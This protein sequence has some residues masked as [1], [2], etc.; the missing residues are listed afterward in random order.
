MQ[1]K[2]RKGKSHV[3]WRPGTSFQG[4]YSCGVTQ[5]ALSSSSIKSWQPVSS[6]VSQGSLL[7]TGF[8]RF[9][10]GADHKGTLCPAPMAFQTPR[11]NA[12]VQH[13]PQCLNKQ[14]R[15]HEPL[16]TALGVVGTLLKT[17]FPAASRGPYI[18]MNAYMQIF[19]ASL[20]T[21]V[22]S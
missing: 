22:E 16:S 18:H 10:G 19:I 3:M 5:D 13:Q 9:S 7:E 21:T 14:I 8:P 1:R 6:A 2:I 15:H 20:F 12:H 11:G 4:F 17:K